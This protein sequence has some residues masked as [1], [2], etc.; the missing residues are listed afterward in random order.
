M[1]QLRKAAHVPKTDSLIEIS[2]L[3][4][5]NFGTRVAHI[6]VSESALGKT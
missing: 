2:N 1:R 6:Q 4:Q 3:K 5:S